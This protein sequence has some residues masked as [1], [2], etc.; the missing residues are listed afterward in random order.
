MRID[1]ETGKLLGRIDVNALVD[2]EQKRNDK[3]DV[4][5]GIAY[6][7]AADRI[8]LTGKNWSRLFEVKVNQK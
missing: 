2:E 6:D 1:P 3:A 7:Q 5:N 4:L 8:F